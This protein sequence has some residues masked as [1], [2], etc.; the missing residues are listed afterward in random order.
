MY[1]L[2]QRDYYKVTDLIKTKNELSVFSVISGIMPGSIYVNDENCPTAALI[3]ASECNLLVGTTSD[4]EFNSAL[5]DIDDIDFWDQLTPDTSEWSKIIPDVHKNRFIR[6][7]YRRNYTLNTDDYQCS[8]IKLPDGYVLEKAIPDNLKEKSYINSNKLLDIISIWCSDQNFMKYGGIY[9]IRK[10]NTIV[11]WSM[12]D[13]YHEGRVEIGVYTDE[14]YRKM[15]FGKTVVLANIN[16]C[17]ERGIKSIGWHC[18]DINK[19]S[20]TIAQKIGF[21]LLNEYIAFTSYP[22]VENLLDLS[23]IEWNGWGEYFEKASKFEPRLLG[24]QLYAYVKANNIDKVIKTILNM[25]ESGKDAQ[26]QNLLTEKDG[27]QNLLNAIK[28]LQSIGMCSNFIKNEWTDFVEKI[29]A[30]S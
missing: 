26:H 22:P 30:S 15:G 16:D 27:F 18:V 20:N 3:I 24:E 7:Y 14:R 21:S 5:K 17:F 6:K 13:C 4:S 10:E 11:S 19:G 29:I 12:V 9:Y 1:K 28:F 25:K 8:P 2:M 23:E